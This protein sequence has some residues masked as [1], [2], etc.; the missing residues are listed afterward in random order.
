M[1][2]ITVE[3]VSADRKAQCPP[4]PDFPNGIDI[5]AGFKQMCAAD[6]PY[7]AECC[8]YYRVQC[9]KCGMTIAY[10]AAGRVD[11]PRRVTLPCRVLGNHQIKPV[12]RVPYGD[13]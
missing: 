13:A 10:T 1:I 4:D 7:P 5:D 2:N 3:F 8:G 11:D 9:H 12:A 6:L